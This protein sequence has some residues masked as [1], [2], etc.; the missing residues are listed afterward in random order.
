MSPPGQ[1]RPADTLLRG[2]P[3]DAVMLIEIEVDAV[4]PRE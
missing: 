3:L 4:I 1:I 2:E